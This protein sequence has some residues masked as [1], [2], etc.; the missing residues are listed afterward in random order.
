MNRHAAVA[1]CVVAIGLISAQVAAADT[2]TTKVEADA[3]TSQAK[4]TSNY[5]R[6]ALVKL[7]RDPRQLGYFRFKPRFSGTVTKATLRIFTTTSSGTGFDIFRAGSSWREPTINRANA[8]ARR[9]PR[10]ARSG[11]FSRHRWLALDVTRAVSH[12]GPVTFVLRTA[13]RRG[14]AVAAREYPKPRAARLVLTTED[15]ATALAPPPTPSTSLT[16]AVTPPSPA[17][18]AFR[19]FDPASAWNTP[20]AAGTPV[21]PMSGTWMR[22]IAD[23]GLPLTSNVDQYTIPI[24][25]F[26]SATPLRT[27]KLSGHFSTYDA[28]DDSRKGTGTAP[29]ITGVPI[30]NGASQSAGDDGQIVLWDPVSGTEYS[31]FQFAKGVDGTYSATNGYRY[32]T[33]NGYFGRFAD[34]QAGRGAGTPYSAGLVRK[35]EIN[36]GRID[37]ALA[38]AYRSPSPELRYP[39]SKSDGDGVAGVDPPEGARL[40]LDPSLTDADF[41]RWGLSPAAKTIARA[42]QRYGMYVVDNS[43]S[44]K[45]F[46]EDRMTAGWGPEI[47]G[48]LP[49]RIPWSAFRVIAA[50]D[51]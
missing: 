18:H 45:I 39:A 50:P 36:Q 51:G 21:D 20:I 15:S 11:A 14:L 24:Y 27:V 19:P 48:D 41:T 3:Y 17:S 7:D 30:P 22:A 46:L 40:Q 32:H 28:G 26:D 2:T 42:L 49:S 9:T 37:H 47:E 25:L 13:S 4:P 43:G 6:T 16:P 8:P 10:L 33:T 12:G 23:N 44:S 31:F 38:F 5:G 29:T 1:T 35:W 34:G